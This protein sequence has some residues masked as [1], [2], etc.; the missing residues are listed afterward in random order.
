MIELRNKT[1]KATIDPQG[2]WLVNFS[3]TSGAILFPRTELTYPDGAVKMRGG[4]HVCLP[5]FGP[6]VE[7]GLDQHGF[8]R[9]LAWKIESQLDHTVILL[10]RGGAEM[11][12][13]LVSR[14][15][16]SLT[17]RGLQM[18]LA[19]QNKG[20]QSLPIAPG[21]HP[22][23]SIRS[24]DTSVIIDGQELAFND[25]SDMKLIQSDGRELWL[26]GRRLR[27]SSSML[28]WAHWTDRAGDYL[29]IE[30]TFDGNAFTDSS[31]HLLQPGD[32]YETTLRIDIL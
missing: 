25:L 9:T 8:G 17:S 11:Y 22:Y 31:Y 28:W 13:D 15:T 3:D 30:P 23:F 7:F 10:L 21:F 12:S 16:Y 18:N 20:S 29:C 5:N 1:Y 4:S 27:L 26:D 6:D 19:L 24:E 14:L 32:E 2:A